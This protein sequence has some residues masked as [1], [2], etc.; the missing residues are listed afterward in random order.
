MCVNFICVGA[1]K[2]GTT[3]FYDLLRQHPDIG[4]SEKKEVHFFDIDEN[5][6]QGIEW[7]KDFFDKSNAKKVYGECTPDYLLYNYVPERIYDTLGSQVRL[8]FLLRNPVLRA[9]SQFNFNKMKGVEFGDDFIEIIS[10]QEL[11]LENRIYNTWFD[12]P[13]YIERG[14][15][16]NQ[17]SRFLKYFPKEQML[18]LTYEELFGAKKNM[19]MDEVFNFLGLESFQP[20]T[21]AKSNQSFV[22]RKGIKGSFLNELRRQKWILR[23]LKRLMPKTLYF[24]IRKNL[25]HKLQKRPDKI[26]K[27]KVNW[28]LNEY[29]IDDIKKLEQLISKDLSHWYKEL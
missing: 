26:P 7:Y 23:S 28:L 14:L 22:P 3:A 19:L 5:Y 15:Y 6:R 20:K 1:Q 13:Y 16:F 25:V 4:L 18:F 21:T 8:I 17:I 12:P 10:R 27:D 2:A 24:E 29:F 11:D 9:Y